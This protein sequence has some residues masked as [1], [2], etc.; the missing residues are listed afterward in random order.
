[1]IETVGAGQADT[2]V[3]EVADVVVLMLQPE[4]GDDLQLEKA[5]LLEV[6][7]VVAIHKADLPGADR[8]AAQLSDTLNLPGSRPI[9]VIR[10]SSKTGEGIEDLIGAMLA[11]PLRRQQDVPDGQH[12][13]RVAQ[14][15]LARSFRRAEAAHNPRLQQLAADWQ[16]G[17]LDA[18]AAGAAVLRLLGGVDGSMKDERGRMREEG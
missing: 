7:D 15:A 13:L 11:T 16:Q 18:A 5:G 9:P 12:L 14:E 17:K 6:A 8:L 1:L 3:S 4:T 10:V 2:A